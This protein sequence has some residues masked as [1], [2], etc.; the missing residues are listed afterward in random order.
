M[1]DHMAQMQRERDRIADQGYEVEVLAKLTGIPR[2]QIFKLIEEHGRDRENLLRQAEPG[3]R[4]KRGRG[5]RS[6]SELA[7]R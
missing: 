6:Q 1:T 2:L 4:A 7:N 5:T 3:I